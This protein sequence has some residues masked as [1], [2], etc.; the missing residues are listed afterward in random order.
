MAWFLSDT[1]AVLVYR[2]AQLFSQES[3]SIHSP[4]IYSLMAL[5]C[6]GWFWTKLKF[7]KNYLKTPFLFM[8]FQSKSQNFIKGVY[9]FISCIFSLIKLNGLTY[10]FFDKNYFFDNGVKNYKTHQYKNSM[11]RWIAKFEF[12]I[13]SNLLIPWILQLPVIYLRYF[14]WIYKIW[15]KSDWFYKKKK[16]S[17]LNKS[18]II[19]KYIDCIIHNLI[20][21][22]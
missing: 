20:T 4:E 11:K 21:C 2:N 12:W 17:F 9:K 14:I 13:F 8:T 15:I 19:T 7:K 3:L 22:I 6:K 5:Y 18:P 16:G 1:S 10:L